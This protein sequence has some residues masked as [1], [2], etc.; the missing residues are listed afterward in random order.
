MMT[1]LQ[2]QLRSFHI[3]N[4]ILDFPG[5]SVVENLPANAG[6]RGSVSDLG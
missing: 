5:G 6:G 3:K 2:L 1:R 4:N